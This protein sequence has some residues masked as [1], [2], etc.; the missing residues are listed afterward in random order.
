MPI[1]AGKTADS[2]CGPQSGEATAINDPLD[3]WVRPDRR[4]VE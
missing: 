4:T 2:P 3:V 1:N